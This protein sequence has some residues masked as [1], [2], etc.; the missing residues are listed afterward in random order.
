[1]KA[2]PIKTED[3]L[4]IAVELLNDDK[5]RVRAAPKSAPIEPPAERD[6]G[7]VIGEVSTRFAERRTCARLCREVAATTQM[8]AMAMGAALECA[9]RIESR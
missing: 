9:R 3:G 4:T 8:G 5:V 7:S 1:M 2:R 6:L